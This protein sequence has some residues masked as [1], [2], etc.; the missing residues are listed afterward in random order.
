MRKVSFSDRYG[1]A[2]D[3]LEGAGEAFVLYD[4]LEALDAMHAALFRRPWVTPLPCPTLGANLPAMLINLG[5]VEQML[6]MACEGRFTAAAF[7]RLYRLRRE[8]LRY[9]R[10]LLART[11][12]AGRPYLSALAARNAARRLHA[13]RFR[14]RLAQLQEVL[15]AKGITLP[16]E[17]L[18]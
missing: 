8:S 13:P 7:W 1:F 17:K 16:P 2:P 11:D 15:S 12:A 4:P 18:R 9:L 10:L 5:L 14:N 6:V 3:M